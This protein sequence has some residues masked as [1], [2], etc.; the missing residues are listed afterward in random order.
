M[1]PRTPAENARMIADLIARYRVRY[2][3]TISPPLV[4]AAN[5][6]SGSSSRPRLVALDRFAGVG[7]AYRVDAR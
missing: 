5:A 2:V 7:A 3:V 6:L 1:A 4:D